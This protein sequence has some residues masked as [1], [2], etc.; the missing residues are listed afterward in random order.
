MKTN[1]LFQIGWSSAVR[2]ETPPR[3]R[4][5]PPQLP[6]RIEFRLTLEN[7]LGRWAGMSPQSA[8]VVFT[9]PTTTTP[10]VEVAD[11]PPARPPSPPSSQHELHT[12]GCHR[13]TDRRLC[14]VAKHGPLL[15][16]HFS[17]SLLFS[18]S[19]QKSPSLTS[20]FDHFGHVSRLNEE[21]EHFTRRW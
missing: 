2:N 21:S 18:I 14:S 17:S 19:C 20:R 16:S 15:L 13:S 10:A 9:W 6:R 11:R 8:L 4:L 3:H 12:H 1:T 7:S 5:P